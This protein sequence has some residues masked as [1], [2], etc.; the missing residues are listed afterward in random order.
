MRSI[1]IV[2]AAALAAGCGS[3]EYR[4]T[5]RAVDANPLCADRPDRPGEP[6]AMDCERKAEASWR[7]DSGRGE[8]IDFRGRD[9][10]G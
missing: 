8:P 6:V 2:A 1:A 9:D 5:N 3:M 10:D 4:D 7:S